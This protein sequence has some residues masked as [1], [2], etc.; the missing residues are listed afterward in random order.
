MLSISLIEVRESVH[1]GP[2]DGVGGNIGRPSGVTRDPARP[3]A[4]DIA[5]GGD[6]HST[7][8]LRGDASVR[9]RPDFLQVQAG[10]RLPRFALGRS[11]IDSLPGA[12]PRL[13]RGP[14]PAKSQE[15][16]LLG[17]ARLRCA[18]VHTARYSS[19]EVCCISLS[20]HSAHLFRGRAERRDSGLRCTPAT[21]S[22]LSGVASRRP[23]SGLDA[24]EGS[25]SALRPWRYP[26]SLR[27]PT[28]SAAFTP[29]IFHVLHSAKSLP[30]PARPHAGNLVGTCFFAVI[31][32]APE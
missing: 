11:G 2:R 16:A 22:P 3:G 31:V 12:L 15:P 5:D 6:V 17:K 18:F 1:S 27:S 7:F 8:G 20:L 14:L 21:D 4:Q 19:A 30:P 32:Q 10:C 23:M 24:P 9:S 29:T 25:L 28:V 13:R 26:A